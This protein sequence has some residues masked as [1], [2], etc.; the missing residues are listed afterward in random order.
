MSTARGHPQG[1]A[2][3]Q[4]EGSKIRFFCGRHKWMAPNVSLAQSACQHVCLRLSLCIVYV[5]LSGWSS[6]ALLRRHGS[7]GA[8]VLEL[9]A[10]NSARLTYH[11]NPTIVYTKQMHE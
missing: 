1:D 7:K 4:R 5:Y 6:M 9:T 11:Y 3:G 10:I 8:A 2:C